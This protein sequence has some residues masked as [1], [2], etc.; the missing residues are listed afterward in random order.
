MSPIS[1][2]VLIAMKVR[3]KNILKLAHA[4]NTANGYFTQR[5]WG[6]RNNK[7]VQAFNVAHSHA[8]QSEIGKKNI[9]ALQAFNL[10]NGYAA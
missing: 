6:K 10:A 5:E 3:L 8:A 7:L 9:K 4:A 2:K 1:E